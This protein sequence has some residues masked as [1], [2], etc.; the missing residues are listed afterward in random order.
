[1]IKP[2][3]YVAIIS[4]TKHQARSQNIQTEQRHKYNILIITAGS[5]VRRTHKGFTLALHLTWH[6]QQRHPLLQQRQHQQQWEHACIFP[7]CETF[8]ES[9]TLH[10]YSPIS[11]YRLP[12][13][14]CNWNIIRT[15]A[16]LVI[17]L[18][19]R[20]ENKIQTKIVYCF[21]WTQNPCERSE[22]KMRRWSGRPHRHAHKLIS[23]SAPSIHHYQFWMLEVSQM[24]IGH[25]RYHISI[26]YTP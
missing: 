2:I 11:F 9:H 12:V 3:D 17:Q 7:L 25:Y 5:G 1:M 21:V 24:Q 20:C 18:W 13:I 15:A 4:T 10:S 16:V 19:L 22:A 23:A 6:T 8:Y 26:Y 14:F